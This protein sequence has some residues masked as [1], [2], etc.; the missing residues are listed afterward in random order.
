M[1]NAK[2][3]AA[4]NIQIVRIRTP[5]KNKG[6]FGWVRRFGEGNAARLER[7]SFTSATQRDAEREAINFYG[8]KVENINE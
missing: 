1:S 7:S 5:G 3:F 4:H 8:L 2:I 6:R